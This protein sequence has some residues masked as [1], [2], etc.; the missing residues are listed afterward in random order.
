MGQEFLVLL[1]AVDGV[2]VEDLAVFLDVGLQ[3]GKSSLE[4]VLLG[5][6]N[7]VDH[8]LAIEDVCA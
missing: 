2:L 6:E 8:V 1:L 5:D 7:V 4:A 3:L